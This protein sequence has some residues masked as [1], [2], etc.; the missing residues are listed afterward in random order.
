MKAA[1]TVESRLL[2]SLTNTNSCL[3]REPG[4]LISGGWRRLRLSISAEPFLMT[5]VFSVRLL[6]IAGRWYLCSKYSILR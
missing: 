6:S 2:R 3:S 1:T 4:S 5:L